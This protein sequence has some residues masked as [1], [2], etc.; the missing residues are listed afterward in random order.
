M[1]LEIVRMVLGPLQNNVYLLADQETAETV[2]ID[3]SFEPK[4]QQEGRS[5][6]A[7]GSSPRSG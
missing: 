5:R 2:I 3:P 6:A 1:K 7:A 4:R